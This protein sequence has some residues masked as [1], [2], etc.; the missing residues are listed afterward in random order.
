MHHLYTD[1]VKKWTEK[2]RT[3][4]CK[5]LLE[6]TEAPFSTPDDRTWVSTFLDPEGNCWQFLGKL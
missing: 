5:I 2:V 3:A 4:G 6:P 1:E